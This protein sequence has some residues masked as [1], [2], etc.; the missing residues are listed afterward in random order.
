MRALSLTLC[1]L[2][3]SALLA[4]AQDDRSLTESWDAA[5]PE[6][7]VLGEAGEVVVVNSK[8]FTGEGVK[9]SLGGLGIPASVNV[10][11]FSDRTDLFLPMIIV[12]PP[13][14]CRWYSVEYTVDRASTGTGV[15]L[16]ESSGSGASMDTFEIIISDGVVGPVEQS[17]DSL[18]VTGGAA[19]TDLDA[20]AWWEDER[21]P[22][23]FSVDRSSTAA[24]SAALG[25]LVD[26][27]DILEVREPGAPPEIFYSAVDLGLLSGDELDAFGMDRSGAVVFSVDASSPTAL[28]N[29]TIAG[30]G[31]MISGG[32]GSN[33]PWALP[34]QLDLLVGD[35]LNGVRLADPG[36]RADW[37]GSLMVPAT[38]IPFDCLTIDGSIGSNRRIAEISLGQSF[39]F[40]VNTP[41]PNSNFVCC[42]WPGR[43]CVSNS[44]GFFFGN[45]VER[46]CFL[47]GPGFVFASSFPNAP[48]GCGPLAGALPAPTNIQLQA[49][50]FPIQ[51]T[52]QSF[53][54]DGLTGDIFTSNA[55]TL[56]VRN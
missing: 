4:K 26:A 34:S 18:G 9:W 55:V 38:T 43:P 44:V 48:L 17:S 5:S 50:G 36:R 23:Y 27:A 25:F 42:A 31:L 29:P 11:G 20:L 56:D 35:E 54:V 22:V 41:N 30:A 10:D 21:Y 14:G 2:L 13:T 1:L 40:G 49:P 16:G 12:P 6:T 46:P 52:F 28:I 51:F 3:S 45:M 7:G 15:V 32:T 37:Q 8:R 39:I 24:L 47:G 33:S 53:I 19:G